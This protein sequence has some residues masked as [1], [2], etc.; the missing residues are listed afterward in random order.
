MPSETKECFGRRQQIKYYTN[1]KAEV[2][3]V[4][5]GLCPKCKTLQEL[6]RHHIK[7]RRF[8]NGDKTQPILYLCTKCHQDIELIISR[9]ENVNGKPKC[10]PREEYIRIA[11]AFITI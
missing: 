9:R 6:E 5:Y 10:L 1:L 7:P 3:M 8:Y 4:A 11:I 2:E